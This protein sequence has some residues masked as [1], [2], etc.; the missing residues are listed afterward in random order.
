M[1]QFLKLDWDVIAGVLAAVIALILH[2]LHVAESDIVTAII[3][4]LLALLLL[5]NLKAESLGHR[6][7]EDVEGLRAQVSDVQHAVV[8][9]DAVLIGPHRLRH[10]F[11]RFAVDVHGDVVWY[12]AC[13][14]MFKRQEVFDV[15][16][17]LVLDNPHV[18]S[19]QLICDES[20]RPIWETDVLPKVQ[21]CQGTGKLRI[22]VWR[23][24][25]QTISFISAEVRTHGQPEVLLSFWG[26]PFMARIIER[27]VPRYIFR[28]Q[29]HSELIAR[30]SEVE[31]QHRLAD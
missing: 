14:L 6:L 7:A 16:L 11:E 8:P 5:R 12:N 23:K 28:I 18:T 25:P 9:P 17:R 30:L 24:L 4:A 20:E 1:K 15:T 2:F 22:P 3:L 31:R 19:I 21:A 13:C 26:E 10:E 29:K 27:S